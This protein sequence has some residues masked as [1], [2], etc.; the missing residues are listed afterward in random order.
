MA[1]SRQSNSTKLSQSES[2]ISWIT[3]KIADRFKEMKYFDSLAGSERYF[4]EG[5]A[6]DKLFEKYEK[7]AIRN[8][9]KVYK[10]S[11]AEATEDFTAIKNKKVKE[12][13]EKNHITNPSPSQKKECEQEYIFEKITELRNRIKLNSL[14][15]PSLNNLNP[16]Q[17][18]IYDQSR[19]RGYCTRPIIHCF[20]QAQK[21]FRL[22]FLPKNIEEAVHPQSL[23]IEMN[24]DPRYQKHIHR[25][26]NILDTINEKG[27][28]AGALACLDIKD[29]KGKVYIH[30]AT[31]FMGKDQD[32]KHKFISF[33][34]D[35]PYYTP[36]KFLSGWIIDMEGIIAQNLKSYKQKYQ[37]F[38]QLQT[39][40]VTR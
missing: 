18:Y 20:Y 10:L 33:N 7:I 31:Y 26:S 40:K 36:K 4:P 16:K 32:G 9:A 5:P 13:L 28:K 38:K 22:D 17:P 37:P 12:N 6:R 24:Q 2:I 34:T 19:D 29:A 1:T 14:I 11:L 39:K 8:H 15:N 35:I 23:V 25:T 21:R 30:H 3:M 27:I